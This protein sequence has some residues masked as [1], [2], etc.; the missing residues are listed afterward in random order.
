M[1]ANR[2][3][4]VL[5]TIIF[6]IMMLLYVREFSVFSNTLEIKR[7]VLISMLGAGVMTVGAV[8]FWRSWFMPWEDH[9]PTAVMILIFSL[10]FAPLFGS[11]LNR[12]LGHD[13]T[14]SF[15]FISETAYFATGYGVLKGEKLNPTGWKL[16]IREGEM[17]WRLSYKSQAYFPITKPGEKILLPLRQ[18]IF[19][20]RVVSLK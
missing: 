11:L 7:L 5:V 3:L 17:D 4:A 8:W 10:V 9:F 16:R 12:G 2:P 18:G 1:K 13:E 15:D 19:G 6:S 20:V 14:Q